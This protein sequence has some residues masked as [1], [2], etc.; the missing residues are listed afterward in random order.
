MITDNTTQLN[1][2]KTIRPTE[3]LSSNKKE[4]L[5]KKS[6]EKSQAL[7]VCNMIDLEDDR[8]T[9]GRDKLNMNK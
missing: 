7:E 9:S 1:I 5:D 6:A 3:F 2:Y 4:S 8:I